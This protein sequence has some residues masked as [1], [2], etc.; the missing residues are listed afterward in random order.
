MIELPAQKVILNTG[1]CLICSFAQNRLKHD[2]PF[3]PFS[4][5]W[6]GSTLR[7]FQLISHYGCAFSVST[8]S[9]SSTS[10]R[11]IDRCCHFKYFPRIMNHEPGASQGYCA[12][13]QTSVSK[14]LSF[15]SPRVECSPPPH[16]KREEGEGEMQLLFSAFQRATPGVDLAWRRREKLYC[17]HPD[18]RVI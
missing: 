11:P 7:H 10:F 15:Y 18:W 2:H 4:R 13:K 6:A 1:N 3:C 14:N 8:S 16:S 5:I 9:C 17:Y 12:G